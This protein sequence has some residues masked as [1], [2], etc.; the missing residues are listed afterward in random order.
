MRSAL[1]F[2]S[3]IKVPAPC[4]LWAWLCPGIAFV[5]NFFGVGHSLILALPWPLPWPRPDIA[6]ALPWPC[7]DSCSG[8]CPGP[9]LVPA[10]AM[11]WPCPGPTL[12]L[13]LTLQLW[14]LLPFGSR[15][16]GLLVGLPW[17]LFVECLGS[18][19]SLALHPWQYALALLLWLPF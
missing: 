2:K 8:F 12:A 15:P 19:L 7:L 13:A 4:M 16:L 18:I 1:T 3:C 10:L 5:L 11:L 14:L 9:C 17:C 6:P